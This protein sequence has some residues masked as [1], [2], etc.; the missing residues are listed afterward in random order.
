MPPPHFCL[1]VVCKKWGA[2]FRELTVS[3]FTAS[4]APNREWATTL[5]LQGG[6]LIN[7]HGD[8][9]SKSGDCY[10]RDLCEDKGSYSHCQ[11]PEELG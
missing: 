11:S 7:F 5:D 9:I 6:P 1:R 3:L 2:Y 10:C 8:N 4:S